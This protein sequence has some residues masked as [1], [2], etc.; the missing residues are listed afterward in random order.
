MWHVDFDVSKF[1]N[2]S[3]NATVTQDENHDEAYLIATRD[4]QSGEELTQDYLEFEAQDD[5]RR[6]GILS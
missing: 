3:N 5:L 6:R 4:I 1:I 2:H